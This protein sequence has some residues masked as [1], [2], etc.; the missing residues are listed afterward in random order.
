[1]EGFRSIFQGVDDPRESNAKKRGLTDM[2]ATL[3]G[4]SSCR[5][6][7]RYAR[8]KWEFLSQFLELKSGPPNLSVNRT[9]SALHSASRSSATARPETPPKSDSLRVRGRS[10]ESRRSYRHPLLGIL[11]FRVAWTIFVPRM[12]RNRTIRAHGMITESTVG[13]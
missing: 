2:L 10:A 6:F 4:W 9:R 12:Q 13:N 11:K 7:A 1:M 3:P 8:G 5:S